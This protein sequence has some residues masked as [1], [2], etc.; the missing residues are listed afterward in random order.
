M[1]KIREVKST[2]I[3]T[4]GDRNVYEH[5]THVGFVYHAATA[6]HMHNLL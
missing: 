6:E 1:S 4:L 3:L 5:N 2:F